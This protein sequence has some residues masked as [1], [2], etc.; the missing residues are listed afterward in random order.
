MAARLIAIAGPLKGGAFPIHVAE[1]GIGRDASSSLCLDDHAVSRKHCVISKDAERF[2]VRDL[3][4][5]NGTLVN[6]RPI[7]EEV[8]ES[9]DELQV[10]G[11]VFVFVLEADSPGAKSRRNVSI[12]TATQTQILRPEDSI[13]F[14]P[15]RLVGKSR[16]ERDLAALLRIST[17]ISRLRDSESVTTRLADLVREVIPCNRA[18]LLFSDEDGPD[19][20]ADRRAA[21]ESV[22]VLEEDRVLSVPLVA[23]NRTTAV[24]RLEAGDQKFDEGHLQFV[25]AVAAIASLAIENAT[26]IEYLEG[27][28]QRLK[29]EIALNHDMVGESPRIREVLRLITRAAPSEATVLIQGESGTGKELVAR[30]IHNNSRRSGKPFIAINCATLNENLLESELFWHEK[31]AFTGAVAQKR[32]NL[33]VAEGRTLLLD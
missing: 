12:S 8:L 25:S 27:E 18:A 17:E 26:H 23:G 11:S 15:E 5:R 21:S 31:G 33:E 2:R 9:G 13:F 29:A 22:T 16:P 4:S 6:Q 20:P 28:N 7:A 14:R 1:F 32:C 19:E 10:G 30:A 24:L 3:Q